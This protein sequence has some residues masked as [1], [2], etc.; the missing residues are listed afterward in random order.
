MKRCFTLRHEN[1]RRFSGEHPDW[2]L[3]A[4]SWSLDILR[5]CPEDLGKALVEVRYSLQD[6]R[7]GSYCRVTHSFSRSGLPL[8]SGVPAGAELPPRAAPSI[9]IIDRGGDGHA[10][11]HSGRLRLGPA[12]LERRVPPPGSE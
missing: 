6:A 10:H 8:A 12:R 3:L 5:G 11:A 4:N 7:L 1:K 2:M 9:G